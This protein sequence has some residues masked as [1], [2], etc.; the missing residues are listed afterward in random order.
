MPGLRQAAEWFRRCGAP[1]AKLAV[2]LEIFVRHLQKPACNQ[3]HA[4]GCPI[5]GR[6]FDD[7]QALIVEVQHIRVSHDAPMGLVGHFDIPVHANDRKSYQARRHRGCV[8]GARSVLS[9]LRVRP[10]TLSRIAQLS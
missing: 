8:N 10:E 6:L 9:T 1:A 3:K 2:A 5:I 4:F 7:T